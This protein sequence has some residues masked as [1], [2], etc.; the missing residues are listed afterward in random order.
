MKVRD[1]QEEEDDTHLLLGNQEC[2][3][4]IVSKR[5]TNH[6]NLGGRPKERRGAKTLTIRHRGSKRWTTG[7]TRAESGRQERQWDAGETH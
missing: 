7:E 2:Y 4:T 5:Q 3:K 1:A 6:D